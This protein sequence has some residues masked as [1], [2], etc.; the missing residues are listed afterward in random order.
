MRQYT[1]L[2][3]AALAFSGALAGCSSPFGD[4]GVFRD[5]SNDYKAAPELAMIDVPPGKD[6]N[7]LQEIYAI[8]DIQESL[9][10]EGDFEVPRPAPLVAGSTD[11]MVRIQKLGDESWALVAMA[12][13]QLWPQVRSFLAGA[14]I[15]VARLDARAGLM[16]TSWIELR[17]TANAR[18][19]YRIE[20][21]VQR[22]T[23]ELH[24]LQQNQAGDINRWPEQSDDIEQEQEMLR[25]VAQYVANS[26]DTAPVSMIADQAISAG[27]KVAL[28]EAPE[29]YTYIALE[30][31]YNRAWASVGRA[32]PLTSFQVT[33][34]DRSA[35]VY[36]ATFLGPDADEGDGW[37]DWLWDSDSDHPLAG[38][39]CTITVT[40]DG[41]NAVRIRL[42]PVDGGTRFEKREEQSV[43]A[44]LKSN[45][46]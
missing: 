44:L 6:A 9:V 11:E 29:G 39:D 15:Q 3:L 22:G 18:F 45:I 20:R 34:R 10:L 41:D 42:Q 38:Q 36:Y 17:D 31:P 2:A 33:D 40:A 32:L 28:Q 25:A 8:P 26:T 35:G 16:E 12:P 37:F 5:K 24:V 21:G 23:A 4:D 1:Y 30:L 19:Q 43:L 46:T 14:G 13:G 7:A 27:G